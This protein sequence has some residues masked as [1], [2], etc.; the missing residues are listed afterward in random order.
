ML[1][2]K[3]IFHPPQS[4]F[5][6]LPSVIWSV[7]SPVIHRCDCK[8]WLF[9]LKHVNLVKVCQRPTPR[10]K[11]KIKHL[12]V[13]ES[14]G[15]SP[16]GCYLTFCR[17]PPS[18]QMSC[19]H[20]FVHPSI[21]PSV[22][23]QWRYRTG[24]HYNLDYLKRRWLQRG[25][26]SCDAGAL[27]GDTNDAKTFSELPA[28]ASW[29]SHGSKRKVQAKTRTGR[30]W[31]SSVGTL[32]R[33]CTAR[34]LASLWTGLFVHNLLSRHSSYRTIKSDDIKQKSDSSSTS[35]NVKFERW[36][37]KITAPHLLFYCL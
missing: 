13:M 19:I 16:F 2:A 22:D 26:S 25:P 23:H 32:S 11:N 1:S 5:I 14:W 20:P 4:P 9:V 29:F 37:E 31:C 15:R 27:G 35:V 21:H 30:Y 6:C 10:E 17:P 28:T 7:T 36:T 8:L 12:N 34:R 3:F 33:K 18:R 24:N